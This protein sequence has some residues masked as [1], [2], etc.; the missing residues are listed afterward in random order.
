SSS[1]AQKD[2]LSKQQTNDLLKKI[3]AQF[4]SAKYMSE[5]GNRACKCIDSISVENKDDKEKSADIAR[6]I[7]KEAEVYQMMIK[8]NKALSGGDL[9]I[10]I[11]V[12]K[13]SDE[14]KHYY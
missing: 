12:N 9:N 1:F 8:M 5:V 6:C 7:D 14:Y 13:E 2:T 11:N 10:T 3:S 4:D